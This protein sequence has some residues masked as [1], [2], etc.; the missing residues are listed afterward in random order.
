MFKSNTH[1]QA[2]V[3]HNNVTVE[4]FYI[5]SNKAGGVNCDGVIYTKVCYV[6]VV[7][8]KALECM[9]YRLEAAVHQQ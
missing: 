3:D 1:W 8:V 6:I 2:G 4:C 9:V 5:D 7:Y